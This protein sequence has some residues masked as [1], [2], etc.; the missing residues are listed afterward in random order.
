M[1][2][3]YDR[4]RQDLQRVKEW[5]KVVCMFQVL[6]SFKIVFGIRHRETHTT[7]QISSGWAEKG[8]QET[9]CAIPFDLRM[10]IAQLSPYTPTVY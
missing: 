9:T 7:K 6:H 4:I 8:D 5:R 1:A 2:R 3:T 10:P